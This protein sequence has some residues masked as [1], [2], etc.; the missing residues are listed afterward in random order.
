MIGVMTGNAW[1]RQAPADDAPRMSLVLERNQQVEIL[2]VYGNWVQVRWQ[3]EPQV[4]ITGWVPVQWMGTTG[5]IPAS[6]ITPT[7]SP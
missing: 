1:L 5:P 4:E 7:P 3:P 2:A 6:I